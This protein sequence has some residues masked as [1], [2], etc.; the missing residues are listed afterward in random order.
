MNEVLI[1]SN[2]TNQYIPQYEQEFVKCPSI[3]MDFKFTTMVMLIWG[4]YLLLRLIMDKELDSYMTTKKRGYGLPLVVYLIMS[5]I[6]WMSLFIGQIG[7]ILNK[8]WW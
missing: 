6:L 2:L 3:V 8:L 4:I 7:S 1:I 5:I